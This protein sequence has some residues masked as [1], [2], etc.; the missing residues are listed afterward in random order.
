MPVTVI[1]AAAGSGKTE[2]ILNRIAKSHNRPFEIYV[3]THALAEECKRRLQRLAPEKFVR[4]IYGRDHERDSGEA[5]CR[6]HELARLLTD[7]GHAVY[8]NLCLRRTL[9]DQPPMKC[10]HY[11][12]CSYVHQFQ[13]ADVYIYPHAYLPLERGALEAWVPY[14]VVID[15]SFIFSCVKTF[16]FPIS[17][18]RH[19]DLPSTAKVTCDAIADAL[20]RDPRS[21]Q[22]VLFPKGFTDADAYRSV[23]KALRHRESRITPGSSS[24]EVEQILKSVPDFVPLDLML[25]HLHVE[26]LQNA[27]AEPQSVV[28][29]PSTGLV[30]IHHRFAINRFRRRAPG[31]AIAAEPTIVI[32][33]ASAS[34][35]LIERYFEIPQYHPIRI[36]RN[37]TVIQCIST[38]SSTTSLVP[39]KNA[40]QRSRMA[41][42]AKLKEVQYLLDRLADEGKRVLAVGPTAV[43]GNAKSG[44][45][46]LLMRPRNGELA[47]FNALR[48][49]D[50]WKDF[51]VVV[52]IG[53]NQ[54][55]LAAVENLARALFYDDPSPLVQATDW[56]ETVRGYTDKVEER[57]VM[58]HV[59]PDPRVQAIL[60]QLREQESLQAVD[61]LRL[62]HNFK[63]KEVILL[64]NLPLDIEVDELLPLDE[65]IYGGSR[66][67]RAL[68]RLDGVL[69]LN[70]KWLAM[71]FPD[72]WKTGE[73]A[74]KDV[75]RTVKDGQTPNRISIGNLSVFAFEYKLKHQRT[76]SR[77]L[78]RS[79]DMKELQ[80]QLEALLGVKVTIRAGSPPEPLK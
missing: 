51:D 23:R 32:L 67:E 55:P 29:D 13:I 65:I 73:A 61:R 34:P 31:N 43:V 72:L 57:G 25:Q 48:G 16:Q 33:D 79:D 37:A 76:W 26:L 69:P 62:I 28:F 46:A 11:D 20:Q 24:K 17:R 5:M 68:D 53:R 27:R 18:L 35:E 41:A 6:K 2:E 3:P 60:E 54:P 12:K 1:K 49:I 15:E 9:T 71:K 50:R 4:I 52:V 75:G 38:R 19:A 47:H 70:S 22:E 63:M 21:L 42:K 64:S 36:K 39:S 80:G 66:V 74:R 14:G 10:E 58:V 59:H 77:C 45:A 56:S 8:P 7:G 44:V 30:T 78:S 40:D